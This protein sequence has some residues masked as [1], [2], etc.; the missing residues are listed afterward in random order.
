[1]INA[2]SGMAVVVMLA[3]TV[4]SPAALAQADAARAQRIASGNCAICHGEQGE[5]SS[6]IVAR[7][8]GQ[9]PEY[10]ARQLADFK[11]GK[12]KN[13]SMAEAVARLTPEEMLALGRHFE[14]MQLPRE[15]A[16][17]VDLAAVG[18]AL[19]VTGNTRSG[20]AACASC[21]GPDAMGTASLPRLAGQL[22]AYI[23]AQL[24]QF[25]RRERTNENAAMHAIAGKLTAMEIAA[26][27]HFLAGQ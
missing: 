25:G 8:A 24:R 12:R 10:I 18:K 1:M 19:Y 13:K 6:D 17:D 22:A 14:K 11:S 20:I 4:F 27:A 23:E 9:H 16:R 7:I 15:P 21:H 2:R 3:A 26:L 5:W